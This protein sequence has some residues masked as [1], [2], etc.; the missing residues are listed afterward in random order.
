MEPAPNRLQGQ[1]QLVGPSPPFDPSKAV[2]GVILSTIALRY[3]FLTK[4]LSHTF[5]ET[6]FFERDLTTQTQADEEGDII[7][8]PNR[9]LLLFTLAQITQAL[10]SNTSSRI[11]AVAPKY[12]QVAILVMCSGPVH[13]KDI[14]SFSGWLESITREYDVHMVFANGDEEVQCWSGWF[15]LWR[16]LDGCNNGT[17]YLKEEAT[18]VIVV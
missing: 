7:L 17:E 13:G 3:Q 18:E 10:P 1:M 15:C 8:S 11:L 14:T 12:R 2:R 9:C 6:T 16:E 4:F 5:P